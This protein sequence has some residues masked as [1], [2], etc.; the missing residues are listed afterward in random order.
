MSMGHFNGKIGQV[1]VD[2]KFHIHIHIHNPQIVR[3]YP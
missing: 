2:M 1:A 3:G